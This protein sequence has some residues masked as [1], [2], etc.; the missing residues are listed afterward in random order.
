MT[1]YAGGL[2]VGETCRLKSNDLLTDRMQIRI[3]EGKG[4]KD[5]YTILSE[6]PLEELREYWRAVRPE[7]DWLFPSLM[8]P[9]QAITPSSASH[10]F[11]RAVRFAGLPKRGGIHSLRHSFA[12]HALEQGMDLSVLQRILG[13]NSLKTTAGYLHV[14]NVRMASAQSPLDLIEPT[15]QEDQK[16]ESE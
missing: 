4:R 5:R 10:A 8:Y 14:S 15:P 9:A 13:H 16:P 11:R 7:G 2:R 3:V 1:T 6:R 12:T